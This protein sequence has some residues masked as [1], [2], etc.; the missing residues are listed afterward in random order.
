MRVRA[1]SATGDYTFGRSQGNFL[2]DSPACVQQLV[3]TRLLLFQGEWF[4]DKTEGMPWSTAVVGT[5][6]KPFYDRAIQDEILNTAG[7]TSIVDYSSVLDARSRTLTVSAIVNT[8]FGQTQITVPVQ[9][10]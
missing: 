2:I 4:L 6:T 3:V 7:V 1:Q 10:P 5:G 8:Q 9:I